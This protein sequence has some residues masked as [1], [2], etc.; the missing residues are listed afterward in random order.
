MHGRIRAWECRKE[1]LRGKLGMT[2]QGGE[3]VFAYWHP[4]CVCEVHEEVG[5]PMAKHIKTKH[6]E[7]SGMSKLGIAGR[8]QE[9]DGG[10]SQGNGHSFQD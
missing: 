9:G 3:F 10:S 4:V 5:T 7:V 6:D 1:M 8:N 2:V